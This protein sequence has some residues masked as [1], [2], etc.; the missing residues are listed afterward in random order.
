MLIR[1]QIFAAMPQKFENHF[2]PSDFVQEL[3]E[4]E[5]DLGGLPGWLFK[6][7]VLYVEA[8]YRF[9]PNDVLAGSAQKSVQPKELELFLACN[10]ARF[11][12]AELITD[13]ADERITHVVIGKDTSGL[14][15]IRETL[16]W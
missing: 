1:H 10:T 6:G 2:E 5:N 13:L 9:Q 12:G 8:E 16:S 11:A 15:P 3:E 7:L 4:H 14:R